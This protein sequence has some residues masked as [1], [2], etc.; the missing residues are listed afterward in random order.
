M[1]GELPPDAPAPRL[2]HLI[3]WA[4]FDGY[5]FDLHALKSTPD[6]FVGRVYDGSPAQQAGLREG[7]RIIEVN[8]V[9]V[10]LENHSRVVERI[11]A[12]PNETLLLVVDEEADRWYRR[13]EIVESNQ[14]N[15]IVMKTLN[16]QKTTPYANVGLLAND[17]FDLSEHVS[18]LTV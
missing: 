12:I 9:N 10:T 8:R 4:N 7:D 5:G 14:S 17:Y 6:Q 15:V 3:K 2:F 11:R 1:Y 13:R 16:L 18:P